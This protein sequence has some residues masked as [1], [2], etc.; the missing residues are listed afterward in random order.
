M[1]NYFP[2][3][4]VIILIPLFYF[5]STMTA[6]PQKLIDFLPKAIYEYE[7][8]GPFRY[9][10]PESLFEYINGGA[11]LFISYSFSQVLSRTYK[12]SGQPDIVV[13]IFDMVEPK[14][15]F[16]VFSHGRERLD[17]T[18]GQGSETYEGAILF[19]KDR[20]Y[21]SIVSDV[22][23]SVSKIAIDKM[24]RK[25]DKLIKSEGDLPEILSWIPEEQLVPESL[26]YFHHYVWLNAFFYISDDNFLH[27][28][29]NTDAVLAKYGLAESRYYLLM[30]QY[31]SEDNANI[32]YQSFLDHYAPELKS[33]KAVKLEDGKWTGSR[34]KKDLLICVF[35]A[36]KKEEVES[37]LEKASN[38]YVF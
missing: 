15:A 21:V 28:N 34:V 37:L 29:E 19:W 24:A 22:E 10:Y 33:E 36:T 30:I 2:S 25:I 5:I 27:I 8:S 12:R 38:K 17:E 16:G 6:S 18:Y 7:A 20:Y 3:K 11:E 1:N 9:Y 35:N 13:E 14:N 26:F 23:T 31:E 32:A 4:K